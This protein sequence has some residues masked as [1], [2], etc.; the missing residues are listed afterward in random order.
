[1][2]ATDSISIVEHSSFNSLFPELHISSSCDHT[3]ELP[4]FE[5]L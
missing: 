4:L 5:R 3:F 2:L 1:M